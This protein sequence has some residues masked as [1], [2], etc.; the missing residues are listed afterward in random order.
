MCS[1][2]IIFKDEIPRIVILI[3]GVTR[4]LAI[5]VAMAVE[6]SVAQV[7]H[8]ISHLV[9]RWLPQWQVTSKTRWI[10]WPIFKRFLNCT[11]EHYRA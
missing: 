5:D 2:E 1:L 8:L 3:T 11:I 7:S 6:L 4:S 10:W 9:S